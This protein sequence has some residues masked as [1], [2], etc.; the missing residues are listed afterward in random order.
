M[1]IESISIADDIIRISVAA[2]GVS[3]DASRKAIELTPT[4]NSTNRF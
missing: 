4:I 3:I 2:T 1:V